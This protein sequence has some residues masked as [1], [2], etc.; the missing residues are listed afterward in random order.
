MD[1]FI[2]TEGLWHIPEF[3]FGL[4]SYE[5]LKNCCQVSTKWKWFLTRQHG[6]F[7]DEENIKEDLNFVLKKKVS[8]Y[9]LVHPAND[10]AYFDDDIDDMYTSK[11]ILE[12]YPDFQVVRDH[13]QPHRS[14]STFTA[15]LS[16]F[17]TMYH[18]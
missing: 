6:I 7:E 13:F 12:L 16:E 14:L 17:K 3:I 2:D 5:D 15:F 1:V 18:L 8:G 4:L 10:H 11:T 9:G